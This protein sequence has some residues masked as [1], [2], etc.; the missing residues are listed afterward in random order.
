MVRRAPSRR[1][2]LAALA[3]LPLLAS[4][5][6]TGP[7]EWRVR[8]LNGSDR[9]TARV[10]E[11]RVRRDT[12][13]GEIVWSGTI[14]QGRALEG[15]GVPGLLPGRY[16]LEAV[17]TDA[18]CRT[19]ASGCALVDAPFR[20]TVELA[21]TSRPGPALCEPTSCRDGVCDCALGGCAD[22]GPPDGGRPD[23]WTPFDVGPP[24]AFV[25]PD[26]FIVPPAAPVVIAPWNG[27]TTGAPV[28]GSPLEDPP[29]RPQFFWE[30]VS[31]AGSYVIELFACTDAD[32]TRC[33]V[34]GVPT[35]VERL[36]GDATRG[37]PTDEL[38]VSTTAPVG[39]RYVFRIGACTTTDHRG[40][41]YSAP[42]YLDVGRSA[43]DIDGDGAGDLLA[44]ARG[45]EAQL[46]DIELG[47]PPTLRPGV[48]LPSLGS[49]VPI[50]DYDG[51]GRAEVA[52]FAPLPE[53]PGGRWVFLD[54]LLVA[55]EDRAPDLATTAGLGARIVRLGDID[56]D[57]YSD[58]AVTATG[59]G[60]VRVQYGGPVFDAGQRAEILEPMGVDR[61]AID[62]CA[63]GDM[64]G[65]GR[66]D[67]AILM[68]ARGDSLLGQVRI[69]TQRMPGVRA[70]RDIP[71]LQLTPQT[72]YRG[73][74]DGL[75][76]LEL[77]CAGDVTGD[78]RPDIVVGRHR[79]DTVA[80]YSGPLDVVQ[81]QSPDEDAMGF[82]LALG[83][84]DGTGRLTI[85]AARPGYPRS[86]DN[87]TGRVRMAIDT[88]MLA[89]SAFDPSDMIV[90]AGS[91]YDGD[92][93]DDAVVIEGGELRVL[94]EDGARAVMIAPPAMQTWGA[95]AY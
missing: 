45:T 10:V 21:L 38:P 5:C 34:D 58:F 37:R 77:D 25:A 56:G 31:G 33:S 73:T 29:L 6:V 35:Y 49:V 94:L 18:E 20:G 89:I 2:G 68:H 76:L 46:H 39:A 57:G 52:A 65:D 78:G 50:G 44:V 79:L 1:L 17:A 23:A 53:T 55:G 14:P 4:S 3:G 93:R 61:F 32:W 9:M 87:G 63:P 13:D 28:A 7:V 24:D 74:P 42:R 95:V 19:L 85:L 36:A 15:M 22:A 88:A 47:S 26:A 11:A 62:L 69:Y 81:V 90:S 43:T 12:C 82:R 67:V 83:D 16:A 80:A 72:A 91:D 66:A 54:D 84:L 86:V 8:F 27:V 30:A 48:T 92:G 64:N 51:D 59:L 40:C 60:A 71:A 70:L 41:A 75:S